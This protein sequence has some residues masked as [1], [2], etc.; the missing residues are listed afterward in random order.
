MFAT[1]IKHLIT[2]PYIPPFPIAQERSKFNFFSAL[3]LKRI[4]E[5]KCIVSCYW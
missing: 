2:L 3:L 1:A 5:K 4:T